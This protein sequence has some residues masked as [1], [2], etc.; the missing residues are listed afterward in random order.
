MFACAAPT[1]GK[2]YRTPADGN[3]GVKDEDKRLS[4]PTSH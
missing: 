3:E 2:A 1:K 4:K